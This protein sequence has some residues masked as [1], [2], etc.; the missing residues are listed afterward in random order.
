MQ[1]QTHDSPTP[2]PVVINAIHR[3][4]GAE[5]AAEVIAKMWYSSMGCWCFNHYGMFWGVE[6]DGYIHT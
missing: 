2:S 1:T 4:F 6:A 5:E 3:R